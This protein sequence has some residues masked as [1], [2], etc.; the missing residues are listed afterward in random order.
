VYL[1]F[2]ATEHDAL[3]VFSPAMMFFVVPLT[4]VTLGVVLARELKARRSRQGT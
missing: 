4:V 2:A 1:V 3:P